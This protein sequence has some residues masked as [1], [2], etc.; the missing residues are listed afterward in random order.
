MFRGQWDLNPRQGMFLNWIF[1]D[2]WADHEWL[3]CRL[4]YDFS[5]IYEGCNHFP[6]H[7]AIEKSTYLLSSYL[8]TAD[9]RLHESSKNRISNDTAAIHDPPSGPEISNSKTCP[10]VGSNPI[11]PG[12][13]TDNEVS[14]SQE[15]PLVL[16]ENMSNASNN[17]QEPGAVLSHADYPS[18]Q[19]P[20]NEIF[21]KFDDN[22]PEDPNSDD[23]ELNSVYPH[24]LVSLTGFPVQYV[25]NA[26]KLIVIWVYEDPTLFRVGGGWTRKILKSGYQ[27]RIFKKREVLGYSEKYSNTYLVPVS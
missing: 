14:S 5:R 6:A 19:L 7:C 12:T 2:H 11:V 10:V 17:S 13:C 4:K 18:D 23:F 20:T 22:V 26:V 16:P 27:L 9:C 3:L 15:D 8:Q 25:L 24:Y 21:K 1:L